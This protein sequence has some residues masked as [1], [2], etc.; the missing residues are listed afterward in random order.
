MIAAPSLA[1]RS[2]HVVIENPAGSFEKWEVQSSGRLVQEFRDGQPVRIPELP[3]PANAGMIPRTLLSEELGGDREPLDVLVL[4]DPLERGELVR[5]VPIA[6]LRVV[7]RLERDDKIIA[8][9]PG[10]P[11]AE[12]ESMEELD[13]AFPGLGEQLAEWYEIARPGSA[14]EVQGLGSRA[15]AQLL[16]AEG[17]LAF[18]N[19]LR[20]GNLPDWDSAGGDGR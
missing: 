6:L 20:T 12:S 16:I 10:T 15:A 7:D 5:A 3:W 19:A 18:E 8:V 14:I 13:Q 1:D 4:G 9:L 2:I 17:A 11:Y